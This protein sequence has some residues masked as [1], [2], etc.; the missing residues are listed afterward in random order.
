[1]ASSDGSLVAGRDVRRADD[2]R[3]DRRN[4]RNK[5]SRRARVHFR[6]RAPSLGKAG[7][8]ENV[9]CAWTRKDPNALSLRGDS[10]ARDADFD[11]AHAADKRRAVRHCYC[12]L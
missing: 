12:D 3:A 4:A 9:N 8:N 11:P 2:A 7:T 5:P 6:P 1:M 10:G